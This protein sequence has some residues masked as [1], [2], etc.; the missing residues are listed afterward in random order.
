[1]T[2]AQEMLA[3]F[4][5]QVAANRVLHT[6]LFG[7]N[8]EQD[9][10]KK[11]RQANAIFVLKMEIIFARRM[12]A[13]AKVAFAAKAIEAHSPIKIQPCASQHILRHVELL[14]LLNCVQFFADLEGHVQLRKFLLQLLQQ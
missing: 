9:A 5:V 14:E 11:K 2:T 1:M 4:A 12:N 7:E 3:T 6:L 13:G 8:Q 10:N